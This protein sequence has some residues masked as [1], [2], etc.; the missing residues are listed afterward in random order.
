MPLSAFQLQ[1]ME[2]PL[3]SYRVNLVVDGSKEQK[4]KGVLSMKQLRLMVLPSF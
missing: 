2:D 1:C 3:Q 4:I